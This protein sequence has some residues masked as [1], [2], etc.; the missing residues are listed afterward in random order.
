MLSS[1]VEICCRLALLAWIRWLGQKPPPA[2][3]LQLEECRSRL[4]DRINKVSSRASLAWP[5]KDNNDSSDAMADNAKA[6]D[7]LSDDLEDDLAEEHE[8]R[9]THG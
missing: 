5:L 9:V 7:L 1:S 2:D 6:D 3:L 8:P 4:Q